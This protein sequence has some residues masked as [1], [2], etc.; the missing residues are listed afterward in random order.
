[1]S[2]RTA[3]GALL[4]AAALATGCGKNVTIIDRP[5]GDGGPGTDGSTVTSGSATLG[6][7]GG[8]VHLGQAELIVPAGAL[9]HATPIRISTSATMPPSEY[10][11]YSALYEFAPPGLAFARPATVV[12]PEGHAPSSSAVY[13]SNP[14]GE[15]YQRLATTETGGLATAKVTHFSTG[16][17]GSPSSLS[18]AG[19]ESPPD[20]VADVRDESTSMDGPSDGPLD[21]SVG[22]TDCGGVCVN[23]VTDSN[24]CGGCAQIC[25][26]TCATGYCQFV[27]ASGQDDPLQIAVDGAHVYWTDNQSGEVMSVPIVG[28]TPTTLASAQEDPYCVAVDAANVYWTDRTSGAVM[29]VPIGGGPL[30]VLASSQTYPTGI[31]VDG[32]NVYWTNYN[33]SGGGA[34]LSMPKGG[35]TL[36]VLASGQD[37]PYGI[38]VDSANVYWT[39]SNAGDVMSLPVGGG[40]PSTLASGQAYPYGIA[41][42]GVSVY[43]TN[44]ISTGTVVSVPIGGGA[45]STLASG[46]DGPFAIAVDSVNV[47]WTNQASPGEVMSVPLGGGT[48]TT[49]ASQSNPSGI[50]VDSSSVYWVDSE[51]PSGN[52]MRITPKP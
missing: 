39:N 49:L 41:T 26:G 30:T 23:E 12:L 44:S 20:A 50:A 7:A 10:D 52:V 45:A 29:S 33:T 2:P 24:N 27:L 51:I 40:T 43:W 16:F 21:C 38:A 32:A 48:P 34:V 15:G 14:D 5:G 3:L 17:V 9:S 46:Q 42:D 11:A 47:Y 25:T 4:A 31:A 19:S 28:G 22:K 37:G 18:D 36:T 8:V 6:P 1:M 13:W 35:G